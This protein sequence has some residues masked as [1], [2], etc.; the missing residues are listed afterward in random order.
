M[1]AELHTKSHYTFLTGA[2][3]PEE[4]V[5]QA[6]ELGYS[7]I[8]ITDECS[9]AGLVKAYK[10]SEECGIKLIVGSE[11]TITIEHQTARLVLLAPSRRAYSEISA[12]ITKGRRRSRK[13]EYNLSIDDLRFGLRHCLA[14]WLPSSHEFDTQHGQLLARYFKQRLWLGVELFWQGNDQQHYLYC[15]RLS[16]QCKLNMVACNDV[17]MHHKKRKPLQDTLTAIRLNTTI[18][19]L[20]KARQSNAERYLKPLPVLQHQYPPALLEESVK[21]ADLCHFSMQELRYEYPREVVPDGMTPSAHLRELTYQGAEQRW[22]DGIPQKAAKII[23]YELGVIQELKYEYYFLTV[24]DIVA[25]ARSQDILCQGR[26]SA[27]NSAVCYC[28]HITEIDPETNQLLFERFISKERNEPPDIDVDFESQRRE[29]VIQ[30]IYQKYSRKRTALTATVITYRRK[31]AIRDVG[32]ALGLPLNFIDELNRSMAWWDK[33]DV[34][35]E[36]MRDQK[37]TFDSSLSMQF[38]K[39]AKQIIG[40][41]RHLSQHVGGFLITHSPTSTLV[42]IENAAMPDRTIIQWDKYDIEILGLLKVDVLGLGMLSAIRRAMAMIQRYEPAISKVQ[43]IPKEDAR[44]YDMLCAGDSVGVFQVESRAQMSMLPRLKPRS[45]YDLVIEV[46]IVRPGPIQGDMVHPYL[47]RRNGE[48]AVTYP[49]PEI[50][51]VL[52]RTLGIP[53]FQEQVIQL[54]MVAAGFSGGE[55]DHLRRAMASWGKNGNLAQ[56]KDKLIDGMLRRGHSHEFADRL[57]KQIQGFGSYGFPESHSASFALLVYVSAWLKCYHPAAF[58]AGILNSQPMGFY[59]PSQLVQDA[60]RHNVQVLPVCINHSDW[61][62]T[63][64]HYAADSPALRLGLRLVKGVSEIS[65]S[66]LVAARRQRP[67]IGMDDVKQRQLLQQDELTKL[68]NANA[69]HQFEGNRRRAYW[70]SLQLDDGLHTQQQHKASF[71]RPLQP[72]EELLSDYRHARGVS[73]SHHPMQLLRHQAPFNRCISA[74]Q[75]LTRRNNSMI[76]IAGVVTGRQRP[77]T[78]SGVIFMTLEDETGNINVV[79]WK[80]IQER[81]RQQILTGRILYIKGTLEHQHGVANVVAGYIEQ[82]DH[83]LPELKTASRNFH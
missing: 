54:T 73:L 45:F 21:I 34:L 49:S 4:L 81:F 35:M 79:L 13:G 44:V 33:I 24:Y 82:L 78:A 36:R 18:Q 41:P 29:E 59:S 51:Q 64:E 50:K 48:E 65:A 71:I 28:L 22:P 5:Y 15:E 31:S 10:A 62:H 11:F 12:L 9:F 80:G 2:S 76:E 6:A 61:D 23:E 47:K 55:A 75:L 3:S 7:A 52:E 68:V 70:Q 32:K 53:I 74:D 20:G 26:G 25:F 63:L 72:V 14:I 27:A 37:M 17:H 1:F 56:F 46:A 57:F 66:K 60:R 19:A 8:A 67:F 58:Y 83:T 38:F 69:F 40:T 43:D 42:P 77:G 30:Y 39:L 16:Q